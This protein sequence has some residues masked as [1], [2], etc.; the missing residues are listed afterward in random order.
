[1]I[2]FFLDSSDNTLI[3][4]HCLY[5]GKYDEAF[6]N[7]NIRSEIWKKMI[8]SV[9]TTLSTQNLLIKD[10]LITAQKI[11]SETMD[12]DNKI[13]RDA[14]P[15]SPYPD[16][17]AVM[18]TYQGYYDAEKISTYKISEP[19]ARCIRS[20]IKMQQNC[21]NIES[22]IDT[23]NFT[24]EPNGYPI[25]IDFQ[26]AV[27]LYQN[28]K[29]DKA[30]HY[31]YKLQKRWNIIGVR[32]VFYPKSLLLQAKIYEKMNDRAR[33]IEKYQQFLDLWK[34]ADP[35]LPDLIEAKRRYANLK[36]TNG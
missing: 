27:C 18:R 17:F 1:L 3:F 2:Q 33:A 13:R 25:F 10:Y 24:W 15:A 26:A 34:N 31:L 29:F 22:H 5:L 7:L 14:D 32:S 19:T 4:N 20:L 6:K 35:D 28:N 21:S 36:G 30:L 23:L 12:L 8:G 9:D 11:S 16:I